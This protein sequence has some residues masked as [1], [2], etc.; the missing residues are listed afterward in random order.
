M[1]FCDATLAILNASSTHPIRFWKLFRKVRELFPAFGWIHVDI[2]KIMRIMN[3]IS[4]GKNQ[5]YCIF[6]HFLEGHNGINL[7]P[8][9][10]LFIPKISIIQGEDNPVNVDLT[11]KNNNLYGLKSARFYKVV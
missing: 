5:F 4:R 6:I 2:F 1:I 3:T 8:F 11:F 7:L 10:P 9:D